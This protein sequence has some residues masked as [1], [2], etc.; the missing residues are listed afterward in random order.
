MKKV[1]VA[2]LVLAV[3][4][5]S[6]FAVDFTGQFVAGYQFN[7]DKNFDN[8]QTHIMGQ[9]GDDS[10][11]TKLVL[12]FADENGYWDLSVRGYL[13]SNYRTNANANFNFDKMIWGADSEVKL[14]LGFVANDNQ[15]G[16]RAY[17][18]GSGNNFDRVRTGGAGLFTKLTAGYGDLIQVQVA[19][20]PYTKKTADG[21]ILND[22]NG[23]K[24]SVADVI[25]SAITK[26]I[27]GLAVSAAWV[28]QG[29]DST[30]TGKGGNLSVAADV[31][32]GALV[33]LD[34]DLGVSVAYKTKFDAGV[35]VVADDPTTPDKD[36][37]ATKYDIANLVAAEVYFGFDMVNLDVEYA[38]IDYA[39][40]KASENYLYVGAGFDVTDAVAI[41]AWI[42]ADDVVN[43]GDT[44]FLG[45][46][47]DYAFYEN[48]SFGLGV[49]YSNAGSWAYDNAGF[50]IVPTL[51]IAF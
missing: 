10:N 13:T 39:G 34:F 32:I 46:Q 41:S 48:M 14:Q 9:D 6:A 2:L 36:E 5:S 42:G 1:L 44:W 24:E 18:N 8:F 49:E 25:V 30:A 31:N 28:Y 21:S 26:P 11:S 22:E 29:D 35:T 51:S 15:A 17:H 38:W 33:D 19:G 43:F 47:V 3:A 4:L 40:E 27:D 50:N 16:L 37:S 45:A 20:T 7:W 12:G 23:Y